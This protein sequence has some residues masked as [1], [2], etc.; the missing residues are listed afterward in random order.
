MANLPKAVQK[1]VEAAEAL[2][3]ESNKPTELTTPDSPAEPISES[4]TATQIEQPA[5]VAPTVVKPEVPEETWES[6]YK[7]LQGLFNTRVHELQGQNKELTAKLQQVF[8]KLDTLSKQPEPASHSQQQPTLDPK[9]VENF[10]QDLVDMVQRQ[11][12]AVLGRVAGKIDAVVADFEKR[13]SQMEQALKGTTQTVAMTA[14][15]VFF[16]KLT[17]L[18]PDW[19]QINGNEQF[20]AWLAET[21]PVY[22]QPRQAA[23]TA[24]QNAMDVNRVANVFKAFKALLPQQPKTDP[25]AKQ[26]SPKSAAAVAP[27]APSEKPVITQKQVQAFYHEVATG[28]Y[29]GREA[30]AQRLEQMINEAMA[31]G[32]IR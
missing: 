15:E 18:V 14:E 25:L 16:N 29:R 7:S 22:G 23:L 8:D 26:V 20:L 17:T 1:Q 5:Q 4:S 28:K 2:L 12:Q 6:R 24:A 19:E 32:R 13:I 30:E 11:T 10:G 21:D 3:A 31:E 27:Q 9:D